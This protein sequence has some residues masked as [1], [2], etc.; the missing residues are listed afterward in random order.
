MFNPD[1]KYIHSNGVDLPILYIYLAGKIC[2]QHIDKCLDWQYQIINTYKNYHGKGVYPI[3]FLSALNSK[4]SDSVDKLGLTSA[5]DP[6]L[7]FLKDLLSIQTAHAIVAN[8]DDFLMEGIEDLLSINS[9][10][11]NNTKLSTTMDNFDWK[12][13]FF[14]LQERILNH[15]PNWGTML[16]IGIAMY[17]QKPIVLIAIN[18]TQ[19]E[20]LRKHP[21]LKRNTVVE[22]VDELLEK[23]ILNIIYKSISGAIY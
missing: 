3:S 4:E 17:L 16:E 2:G 13:A 20:M 8:M 14:K 7:I 12:E 22:S 1:Q 9:S 10:F 15:R 21:F 23:K 18:K 11:Y 19:A 5:L 6:S